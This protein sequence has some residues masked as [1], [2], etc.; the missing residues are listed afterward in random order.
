VGDEPIRFDTFA[1]TNSVVRRYADATFGSLA[2]T[3][4]A[5]SSREGAAIIGGQEW[6]GVRLLFLDMSSMS[7][8][9]TFKDWVACVTIGCCLEENCQTFITQSSGNTANA[10]AYY[11]GRAGI[12]VC[13]LYPAESRYKINSKLAG[14]DGITFVEVVG[15]EPMVKLCA[16]ALEDATGLRWLPT[17]DLQRIGNGLRADFVNEFLAVRGEVIDWHAQALSSA[18][19][20]LGF[21]GRLEVLAERREWHGAVPRFLGVQQ[22][23]VSPYYDQ[24]YGHAAWSD[25]S[26]MVIEPTLF[27]SNPGN[28]LVDG[29]RRICD[30]SRG[31]IMVLRNDEYFDRRSAAVG[32]L[33][34]AGLHPT[35]RKKPDGTFGFLEEAGGISVAGVLSE[36]D[37]GRIRP[38]ETVLIAVT[39]GF[40]PRTDELFEPELQ[41]GG[42]EWRHQLDQL[43]R[44][45]ST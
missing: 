13:I 21:Y 5:A 28:V 33:E 8:T 25:A 10:L 34:A 32:L 17:L 19:G 41:I 12:E 9:G 44:Q 35:Q 23:A 37:A 7:S 3:I 27:R 38:G 22:E 45:V 6:Q 20:P 2:G 26:K 11:A 30:A 14:Q 24:I 31:R 16:E 1:E 18:F 39:G 43:G 36:I 4:T 40:C 42:G 29:V 15:G